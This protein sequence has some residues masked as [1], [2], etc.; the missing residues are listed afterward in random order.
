MN[1]RY[2]KI[3]PVT[4]IRPL[5]HDW[6]VAEVLDVLGRP[7]HEL[8]AEAHAVHTARFDANEVEGAILLSIKTGGCP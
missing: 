3:R 2:V 7:F 6:T 8:L 1:A 4:D 5:R